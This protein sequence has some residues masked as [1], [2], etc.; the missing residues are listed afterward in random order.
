MGIFVIYAVLPASW[1]ATRNDDL[2]FNQIGWWFPANMIL[3]GIWLPTFQSNTTFGFI[4]AFIIICAMLTTTLVMAKRACNAELEVIEIICLRSAM[5]I[6]SGWL[7]AATILS[8]SIMLKVLGMTSAAGATWGVTVL[9][10]ALVM[11]GVNTYI[12]MDPLFG[13]VFIWAC[14][15]IKSE[16]TNSML[17]TNLNAMI[18]IMSV[19]V[20]IIAAM[21][22]YMKVK[23]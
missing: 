1:V 12:N 2:I 9:W 7:G 23:K 13:G 16:N 10:I 18:G 21:A 17:E 4:F 3:N 14:C 15:G 20:G 8:F 22:I 19:Y 6:Y 5:S 11:Y